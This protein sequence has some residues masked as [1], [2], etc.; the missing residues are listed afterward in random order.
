[1]ERKNHR[2]NWTLAEDMLLQNCPDPI[3]FAQ[4]AQELGRTEKACRERLRKLKVFGPS[5]GNVT[6]MDRPL[7]FIVSGEPPEVVSRE[8]LLYCVERAYEVG[9][10]V[11]IEGLGKFTRKPA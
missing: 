10:T 11:T 1:M 4:A 9:D 5:A 7:S 8:V 2:S 6:Q 3:S